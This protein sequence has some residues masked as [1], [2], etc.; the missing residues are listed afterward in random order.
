MLPK[1]QQPKLT[2]ERERG[3]FKVDDKSKSSE[4]F[5]DYEQ[6]IPRFDQKKLHLIF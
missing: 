4:I 3:R 2:S 5:S 6:Q 1:N